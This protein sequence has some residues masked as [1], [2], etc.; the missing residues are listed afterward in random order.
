M[1]CCK[2]QMLLHGAL[3]H[4]LSQDD[5]VRGFPVKRY[6]KMPSKNIVCYFGWK[7]CIFDRLLQSLEVAAGHGNTVNRMCKECF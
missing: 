5:A 1:T 6:F 3:T 4:R 7:F 2:A